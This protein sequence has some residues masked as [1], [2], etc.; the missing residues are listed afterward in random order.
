MSM[1][2]GPLT[3]ISAQPPNVASELSSDKLKRTHRMC[4]LTSPK[5]PRESRWA[6]IRAEERPASDNGVQENGF[7]RLC[8]RYATYLDANPT[9]LNQYVSGMC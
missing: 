2:A 3:G 5:R 1:V 9:L 8:C 6:T 7:P 4:T